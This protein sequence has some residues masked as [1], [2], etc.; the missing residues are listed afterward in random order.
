VF[1][2]ALG[3]T[4]ANTAALERILRDGVAA[5]E[6]SMRCTF[7]DGTERWVVEWMMLGRLG[8]MRFISAWDRRRGTSA[9]RLVSCYMKKVKR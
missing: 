7:I 9:P 3:L 4:L 8:P 1:E 5:H 6:A 2:S